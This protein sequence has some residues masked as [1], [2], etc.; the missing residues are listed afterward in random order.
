MSVRGMNRAM[1]PPHSQSIRQHTSVDREMQTKTDRHG[2]LRPTLPS[3]PVSGF[4][5]FAR[6]FVFFFFFGTLIESL[7]L[8]CY[9]SALCSVFPLTKQRDSFNHRPPSRIDREELCIVSRWRSPTCECSRASLMSSIS[10]RDA[11][12]AAWTLSGVFTPVPGCFF[13]MWIHLKL[14]QELIDLMGFSQGF[15]RVL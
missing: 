9:Q 12:R 3:T 2:R 11:S 5:L 1:F 4:I 7:S 15:Y 6:W 14:C 10:Q 13:L 8:R